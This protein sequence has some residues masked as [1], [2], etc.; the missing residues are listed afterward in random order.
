MQEASELEDARAFL[1]LLESFDRRAVAV[2]LPELERQ[3]ER[4]YSSASDPDSKVQL[5]TLHK[6]KGLE[7]DWV[8]IPGLAR[9][10]RSADRP[11]LLLE[12]YFSPESRQ[13]GMLF[14]VNDAAEKGKQANLNLCRI[15]PIASTHSKPAGR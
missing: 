7:F 6:A 10:P 4:L 1:E 9:T 13:L 14:A 11:M 5:M 8:I 12:E 3:V 2:T 15:L